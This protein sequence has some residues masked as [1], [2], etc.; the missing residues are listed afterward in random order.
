MTPIL[1]DDPKPRR[2]RDDHANGDIPRASVAMSPGFAK[3]RT[4]WPT[5]FGR[6]SKEQPDEPFESYEPSFSLL[7][8]EKRDDDNEASTIGFGR[9]SPRRGSQP[10]VA[11][12]VAEA[13]VPWRSSLCRPPDHLR[14]SDVYMRSEHVRA[15]VA[16]L[17]GSPVERSE[18]TRHGALSPVSRLTIAVPTENPESPHTLLSENCAIRA[19]LALEPSALGRRDNVDHASLET[20]ATPDR[21]TESPLD[22]T[23]LS[24]MTLGSPLKIAPPTDPHL[25]T[26]AVVRVTSA[27]GSQRATLRSAPNPP[28]PVVDVSACADKPRTTVEVTQQ[29]QQQ[30]RDKLA[31]SKETAVRMRLR[32]TRRRI[33]RKRQDERRARTSRRRDM[34]LR[35]FKTVLVPPRRPDERASGD[36][37]DRNEGSSTTCS[38]NED[39]NAAFAYLIQ[40]RDSSVHDSIGDV[41]EKSEPVDARGVSARCHEARVRT[42]RCAQQEKENH[43]RQRDNGMTAREKQMHERRRVQMEQHQSWLREQQRH[44]SD[45]STSTQT[46]RQTGDGSSS[47]RRRSKRTAPH[48]ILRRPSNKALIRNAIVHVCLAGAHLRRKKDDALDV[49]ESYPGENFVILFGQKRLNFR[50]LYCLDADAQCALKVYGVGPNELESNM[51][52]SFYKFSSGSKSFRSLSVKG[53]TSTTDGVSLKPRFWRKQ[54]RKR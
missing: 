41:Q 51:V 10:A 38:S 9:G 32:M 35:A 21:S 40:S 19:S 27:S 2:I 11:V 14:E 46:A 8:D 16:A 7:V 44:A 28:L 1:S 47:T 15:S 52:S 30:P 48:A 50:G 45:R 6:E 5:W 43:D 25:R 54:T 12:S 26:D 23:R 34:K 49:L 24:V 31:T 3:T 17:P 39:V 18:R 13:D 33:E 53:F 37:N 22:M 4:K 20:A 36:G 29:Q 42:N